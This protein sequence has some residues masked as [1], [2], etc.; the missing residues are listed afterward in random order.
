AWQRGQTVAVHGWIYGL[1]DG[2]LRDLGMTI[3]NGDQLGSLY[4]QAI[5][6]LATG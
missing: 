2:R 5:A 6:R 3:T 4:Q 1:A